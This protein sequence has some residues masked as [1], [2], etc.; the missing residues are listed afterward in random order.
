MFSAA[1]R[2]LISLCV[3]SSI[4]RTDAVQSHINSPYMNEFW[5]HSDS[6][7]LSKSAPGNQWQLLKE[8]LRNVSTIASQ[9]AQQAAPQHPAL[10]MMA[11]M[12]GMLHDY[13]KYQ[14]CFQSMLDG[15]GSGCPHALS[16]AIAARNFGLPAGAPSRDWAMP[17]V[18]AIAAHHAGLK[19]RCDLETA[20][21]RGGKSPEVKAQLEAAQKIWGHAL[22][23]Q[24][25][26]AS[27]LRTGSPASSS[28]GQDLFTRMLLSCLVDADRLD[29]A[30]RELSSRTLDAPYLLHQLLVELERV[31]ENARKRGGGAEVLAVRA[32]VQELCR[33]AGLSAERLLSLTVPTGGGKTLAAMRFALERA[34]AKPEEVRRV[35]VVIPFLSIIEQNALVY[36]NIFGDDAVL[37]HHSGA[38]YALREEGARDVTCYLPMPEK[39]GARSRSGKPLET[40]NWDAPLIVTTSVR[41]FESL[42]SNHPSDLRRIHNIAGSVIILDEVQTLPRRLL[43]PLLGML[44]E[45]TLDWGCTVVMATAT[46][47]AFEARTLEQESYLWPQGSMTPIVPPSVAERMHSALRRV[48]VEWR[49]EKPTSWGALSQELLFQNQVLCVVNVRDHAAKL[50]EALRAAATNEDERASIFHL[51]TRMCAQHRLDVLAKIRKRLDSSDPQPCRI[52]STQLIEAGVDL[53]VPVAYRALGPMDAIVQVA[54]RVDREGGLTEAAGHPAGRLIVF[55]TEDGRM[56]PHEYKHATGITET[57]AMERSPQ[58]DDLTAMQH[59]FERYYGQ[60]DPEER[61]ESLARMREDGWLQFATLAEQFEY[62]NSRTRNV[63]VPYGEGAELLSELEVKRF[64]DIDLLRKLQRYS[65]GLQPWEFDAAKTATLYELWPGSDLWACTKDAY[66]EAR[67]LLPEIPADRFIL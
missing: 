5:A 34:V 67:G 53:S 64:L 58:T 15:S 4:A 25:A 17:A 48:T 56:P 45:L 54:G 27:V 49:L 63:F 61:G 52:V 44:R 35:I 41:F 24:P 29:T 51:S 42:F 32:E 36:R 40:E 3:D 30:H 39:E 22:A 16:G 7:G 50:Y 31:K 62:I 13:G 10:S 12:S 46:Q 43:A 55:R 65:V 47:P 33:E 21:Q 66:E 38:V 59:Y 11:G 57:L 1:R 8:H 60:A 9:L 19:D 14:L 18:H 37:E 2:P 28:C 26:I 6:N 23:D 20:T